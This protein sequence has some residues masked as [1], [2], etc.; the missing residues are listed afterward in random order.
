[1]RRNE[2]LVGGIVLIVATVLAVMLSGC[3]DDW[4]KTLKERRNAAFTE[5]AG[6]CRS[7]PIEVRFNEHARM[8]SCRCDVTFSEVE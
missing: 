7:T 5:C 6:Y 4:D 2:G 3:E 8:L 1:M